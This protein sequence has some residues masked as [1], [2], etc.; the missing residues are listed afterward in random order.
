MNQAGL[1]ARITEVLGDLPAIAGAFLGGSFGRGAA[2]DYSDVDVFVVVDDPDGIPDVLTELA[3]KVATISPILF[4]RTLPNARTINAITVDWLRFDLTVVS[5]AELAYLGRNELKPLLDPLE[6]L[7]TVPEGSGQP[8]K[9][10]PEMLLEIVHEFI[11]VL[12]LSVVVKGRDDLVV[13]ETGAGL[14]RDMLIRI[15]VLENAPQPIRGVLSAKRNLTEPQ[16]EVLKTLPPVEATW[17]S[18]FA[19][20]KAIGE[21]FLPRARTLAGELGAR[22]PGE[23]EK[24]TLARLEV[25][26]GLKIR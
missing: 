5:P 11:R 7:Q 21:R 25:N 23:F 9:P 26:L 18:I 8:P 19:R 24:A 4:S 2:D 14:L 22:W 13:A 3:R 1:I 16:I 10:S 15:M 12:G 6:I 20:T 17:L